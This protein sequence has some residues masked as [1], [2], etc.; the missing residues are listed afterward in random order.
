MSNIQIAKENVLHNDFS[1]T[2]MKKKLKLT[3]VSSSEGMSSVHTQFRLYFCISIVSGVEFFY[4]SL[5]NES[6]N[7][8]G[9]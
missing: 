9:D 4:H 2:R 7:A 6:F 8:G 5:N 1:H 3:F